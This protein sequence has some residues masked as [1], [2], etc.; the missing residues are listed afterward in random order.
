VSAAHQN[1]IDRA[2]FIAQPGRVLLLNDVDS[3]ATAPFASKSD[4]EATL[5]A[6]TKRLAA[7]Q[8]V[9]YAN[10]GRALLVILQGMDTA[11]KDGAIRHVMAGVSPQGIDVHAFGPPALD[12]L[13]H[14]FLWRCANGLPARGRIGIFN[15]SYYEETTIVRVHES[16]LAREHVPQPAG[17]AVWAQR[18]E[19][20]VA[21]ERHLVRSGTIVLKFFLHLSKDE[22]RTR[23]LARCDDPDKNWKITPADLHERTFWDAYR[24]AYEEAI[25]HTSTADAPWYII[26]ADH[27]WFTRAAVAAVII[28]TLAALDL[29]YP[30][31]DA[32]ARS[33]LALERRA[34]DA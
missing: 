1:E 23:L 8:D 24:V 28:Q 9:F 17:D 19:D 33:Q 29:R 13:A 5:A 4:A 6:A 34:L 21:F 7:L 18:F 31:L 20:I 16:L 30:A 32:L 27:K 14:D 10:R 12:E 3:G 26:P 15:R 22:Q 2:A 25:S 11:G